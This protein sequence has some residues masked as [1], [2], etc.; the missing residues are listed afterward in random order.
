[1]QPGLCWPCPASPSDVPRPCAAAGLEP[2]A[3]RCAACPVRLCSPSPPP[4]AFSRC[5]NVPAVFLSGFSAVGQGDPCAGQAEG[6][7]EQREPGQGCPKRGG[8]RL[9]LGASMAGEHCLGHNKSDTK[10]HV[11]LEPWQSKRNSA[12]GGR[13]LQ[14]F[15]HN[16]L[17]KINHQ[18][19]ALLL[20]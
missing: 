7:A 1:M 11:H 6:E 5:K 8:P 16:W 14:S 18:W 9:G 3:E 17:I 4:H 13:S 19:F 10:A 15:E 20:T 2:S 12:M